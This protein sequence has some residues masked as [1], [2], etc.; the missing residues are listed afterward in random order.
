MYN[1]EFVK[2]VLNKVEFE[3]KQTNE[4]ELF[5]IYRVPTK[6]GCLELVKLYPAIPYAPHIHDFCSAEFIF[7]DGKGEVILNEKSFPYSKGSVYFV[8]AGVM[9][10]FRI[11][12]ETIFLS[13]QSNPIQ[14]RSTGHIDI[15]Y[16]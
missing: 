3:D 9:H 14:D 8:P 2:E 10:G 4:I 5:G 11:D 15:R 16:S 13:V 7:L 1:M 6:H 12:E